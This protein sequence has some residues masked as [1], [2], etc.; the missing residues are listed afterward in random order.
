MSEYF[1]DELAVV[2][3]TVLVMLVWLVMWGGTHRLLPMD[4]RSAESPV[5][6]V[7]TVS[8]GLER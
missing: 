8:V 2:I 5:S 1:K 6:A 4:P 3:G 7:G